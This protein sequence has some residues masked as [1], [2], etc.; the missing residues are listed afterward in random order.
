M[1]TSPSLSLHAEFQQK[2]ST[3]QSIQ[4]Y[5][6]HLEVLPAQ[7]LRSGPEQPPFNFPNA[8]LRSPATM[9]SR[10]MTMVSVSSRPVRHAVRESVPCAMRS[11]SLAIRQHSVEDWISKNATLQ[12]VALR[13]L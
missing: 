5:V 1:I 7:L 13:R 11:A 3:A 2:K 12:S 4:L 6:E 8:M 10:S 9:V